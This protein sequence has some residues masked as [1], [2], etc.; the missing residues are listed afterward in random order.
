MGKESKLR[1]SMHAYSRTTHKRC[2]LSVSTG[3]CIVQPHTHGAPNMKQFSIRIPEDML[4]G[5]DEQVAA[6]QARDRIDAIRKAIRLSLVS[7]HSE[8]C[9]AEVRWVDKLAEDRNGQ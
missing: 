1:L 3:L 5:L 6:G 9:M 2:H 8:R 7:T 4:S